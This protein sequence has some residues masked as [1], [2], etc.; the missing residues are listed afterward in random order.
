MLLKQINKYISEE[1]HCYKIKYHL[2]FGIKLH[3][4]KLFL[5]SQEN[6]YFIQKKFIWTFKKVQENVPQETRKSAAIL[7][8]ETNKSSVYSEHYLLIAQSF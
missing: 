5:F 4:K 2:T 8:F 7:L 3:L 1:R 6:I